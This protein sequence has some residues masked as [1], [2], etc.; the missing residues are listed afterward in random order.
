MPRGRYCQVSD[1]DRQRLIACYQQN[2][3][4]VS[5][6]ENL[7]IKRTTAYGIIKEWK[8]S[9]R[10]TRLKR[11]GSVKKI[12]EEMLNFLIRSIEEKPTITLKEMQAKL[13]DGLPDK[14]PVSVQTL[15]RALDG[16]MYTVKDLRHVPIQWNDPAVKKERKE[17]FNWLMNE[18]MNHNL[19][20]LD[21]F[22]INCW[23]SRTKGRAPVGQRA[24]R[25]TT[26]QRGANLTFCLAVSPQFGLVH[27]TYTTGK[28][29]SCRRINYLIKRVSYI[30]YFTCYK[31]ITFLYFYRRF[32]HQQIHGYSFG[33]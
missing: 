29:I 2:K 30:S 7:N 23:T 25:I 13:R 10:Q 19:I 26:K 9:G 5:L 14:P 1:V 32:H 3:D 15:S 21:E 31:K 27:V 33:N 24:V 6:A 8:C 16:A 28:Q 12:D 11:G 20:Y 18:G 22:G 4:W 17:H